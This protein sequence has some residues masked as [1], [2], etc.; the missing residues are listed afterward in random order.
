MLPSR[1]VS[2][3]PFAHGARPIHGPATDAV[4][5]TPDD[6]TDLAMVAIALYVETGDSVVVDTVAARYGWATH[7]D[8]LGRTDRPHCA[9]GAALSIVFWLH[10]DNR[11]WRGKIA[12][13]EWGA[14]TKRV[15]TPGMFAMTTAGAV[16]VRIA[17]DAFFA[18][19]GVEEPKYFQYDSGIVQSGRDEYLDGVVLS[20]TASNA[21]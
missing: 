5:V 20:R 15:D 13:Q 4:P 1:R 6:A 12:W 3:N 8:M 14:V 9:F 2:A 10:C 17:G 11:E 19:Y 18:H 21:R 16:T 7:S